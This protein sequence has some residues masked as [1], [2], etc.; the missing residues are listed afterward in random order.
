MVG[1]AL[2]MF[3]YTGITRPTKDIDVF[4]LIELTEHKITLL[5]GEAIVIE[6]IGFVGVKGFG[7][8]FDRY[9]LSMFGEEAMKNFVQEAVN[10]SL[11][12]DRAL[13]RLEQDHPEIQK[14]ALMHYAPIAETVIGEPKEIYPFLGSSHLVEPLQRRK[15]AAA[16][17]G[18]AHAGKFKACYQQVS[19]FIMLLFPY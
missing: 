17:H 12:L 13:A 16:F 11:L 4:Y 2:A 9:M 3:H 14:V 8:G 15:V 7:G 19:P 6:N 5:D 10:E 18:H 1:S